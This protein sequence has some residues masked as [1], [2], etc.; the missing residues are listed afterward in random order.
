MELA[1]HLTSSKFFIYVRCRSKGLIV[2]IL[3][4]TLNMVTLRS[5]AMSALE[6]S[7]EN[8][9]LKV[10]LVANASTAVVGEAIQLS[11]TVT[12]HNDSLNVRIYLLVGKSWQ[13]LAPARLSNGS[14]T[15]A[16]KANSQG[17]YE[18][19]AAV[20]IGNARYWSEAI[21]IRFFA[22]S[23]FSRLLIEDGNHEELAKLRSFRE[24]LRNGSIADKGVYLAF[25]AVN[26]VLGPMVESPIW[27]SLRWGLYPELWILK[28]SR[29]AFLISGNSFA[30]LILHSILFGFVYLTGPI[31]LIG[32]RARIGLTPTRWKKVLGIPAL[33]LALS[34]AVLEASP[35]PELGAAAALVAFSNASILPGIFLAKVL[36]L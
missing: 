11:V 36:N 24:S 16:F 1:I 32:Y 12:P 27:P 6:S 28:A 18:L 15:Y 3:V 34:I 26:S 31:L 35:F 7:F 23:I 2:L 8:M 5:L 19:R 25:V 29:D 22:G 10:V 30:S 4:L 14:F 33:M 9:E 21:A 17:I 13:E 20:L